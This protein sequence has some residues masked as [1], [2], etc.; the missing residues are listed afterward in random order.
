MSS[1]TSQYIRKLLRVTPPMLFLL[2]AEEV[3]CFLPHFLS[4]SLSLILPLASS[5][6]CDWLT[7]V[8][9]CH[10]DTLYVGTVSVAS[11]WLVLPFKYNFAG[12]QEGKPENTDF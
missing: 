10:R 6:S 3:F 7:E 9:T 12:S 2:T 8:V 5:Q 1:D 4:Q 11:G